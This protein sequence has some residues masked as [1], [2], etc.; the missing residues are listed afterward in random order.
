MPILYTCMLNRR[1]EVVFESF[2]E[3]QRTSYKQDILALK[4][5]FVPFKYEEI[6]LNEEAQ[7]VLFYQH[8]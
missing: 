4:N 3:R 2:Y 8:R 6:V 7:L 5:R 1:K